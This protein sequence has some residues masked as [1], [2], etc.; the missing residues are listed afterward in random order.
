LSKPPET[1]E[2][3]AHTDS[4]W[5]AAKNAINMTIQFAAWCFG[6]RWR[7]A[8]LDHADCAEGHRPLESAKPARLSSGSVA[9]PLLGP[10]G[11]AVIIVATLRRLAQIR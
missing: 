4:S 6:G 5:T 9:G 11:L 1:S 10:A 7:L 3:C 2:S 8:T